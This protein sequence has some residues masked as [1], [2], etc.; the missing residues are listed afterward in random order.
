MVIILAGINEDIREEP[1]QH[2]TFSQMGMSKAILVQHGVNGPNTHN[3]GKKPIDGIFLTN[4]LIPTITSGY[5]SFGEES[6]AII[7]HCG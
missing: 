7:A 6:P 3:Q 4:A 2:L 5:L 1:I